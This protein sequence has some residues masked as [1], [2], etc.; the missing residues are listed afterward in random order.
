MS[1]VVVEGGRVSGGA[2][3][4]WGGLG[5]GGL[6]CVRGAGEWGLVAQF[7]APL[8]GWGWGGVEGAGVEREAEG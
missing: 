1:G 4:L 3:E 2:G 8:G 5:V 6:G 7:P